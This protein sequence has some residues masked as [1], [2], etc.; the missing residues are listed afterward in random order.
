MVTFVSVK[1]LQVI[2]AGIGALTLAAVMPL[3]S[4]RT[5]ADSV[6]FLQTNLA[7]DIPGAAANT[8]VN[9]VNPWGMAFSTTSPFWIAN[10]GA[11]VASLHTGNGG[12]VPLVVSTPNAP[13]G[14]VFN[15]SSTS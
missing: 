11:D 2:L 9:L 13:T 3:P 10:E 15:P 14:A 8:D 4:D 12:S 7:S 5:L 6:G 1:R